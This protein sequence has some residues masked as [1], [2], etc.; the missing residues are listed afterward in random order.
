MTAFANPLPHRISLR[1]FGIPDEMDKPISDWIAA[2]SWLGNVVMSPEQK[3]EAQHAQM[4]FKGYIR[5]HL[6]AVSS[7]PGDG[8][9][10]M[11]LAAAAMGTMDDEETV[12]N[13]VM[14][15]AG[16]RTTLT[17]L[18]NGMVCL[19]DHP[20]QF[21]HLRP[22]RG[23]MR[24]AIEEMLRFEPD[25]SI[26]PRV[27]V[28]GF[29]LGG[30]CIPAGA[31]AIGLV[32][33]I[34]R[35]PAKFD[36]PNTFDITRRANPH[37]AFG[38]GPHICIGKALARMTTQVALKAFLHDHLENKKS[39]PGDGFIGLALSAME[40]GT[41]DEEETLNNVLGL[42][43]GNE[44]TVN[45]HGN[46]L[47][48]LLR[49]PE[50]LDRLR[51]DSEFLKPAIEEMLRYEPSINFILR[52]AIEDYDCGGVTIPAGSMAIGLV[53]A[54]NRDPARFQDP[55]A[56]DIT[57]YPNAQAIFGG[58]PHV[59]IGAALERLQGH[60]AFGALFDRFSKIELVEDPVWWTDRTNQRGLER[61]MVR[62]ER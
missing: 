62:F 29:E 14:L 15:I 58:G 46:G 27:G 44:T 19:L 48:S 9:V 17:L 21:E 59:C 12:N 60:S 37:F 42:V 53:G 41:I 61:L 52:V 40:E 28:K 25:S 11:S 18:G 24:T 23:T 49:H 5:K 55:E 2:L 36:D 20:E 57:R 8:F 22:N 33:A 30:V 47:L 13:V 1:L 39:D 10:A 56:F 7:D 54:I 38:A 45:L 35:D 34:N 32:G 43:S 50:A 31:M 4:L 51:G 3:R 26:I 16:S 6:D